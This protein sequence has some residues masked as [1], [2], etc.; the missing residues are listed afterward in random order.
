MVTP[1]GHSYDF[2]S[3][4]WRPVYG[5]D[6]NLFGWT[7]AVEWH[8]VL[9]G[10][11]PFGQLRHPDRMAC[12]TACRSIDIGTACASDL[13]ARARHPETRPGCPQ[14]SSIQIECFRSPALPFLVLES[15]AWRMRF[16]S[17]SSA[18]RTKQSKT[19]IWSR[20]LRHL[21]D[22]PSV[23]EVARE[24]RSILLMR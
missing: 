21:E 23:I 2:L 4:A 17:S 8:R 13:Q 22:R 7:R 10:R 20:S 9:G 15:F 11:C 6:G 14:M 18:L 19:E 12:Q 3:I 24:L 16:W 5:V 1:S